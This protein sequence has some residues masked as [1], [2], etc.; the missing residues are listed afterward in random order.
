MGNDRPCPHQRIFSD[1]DA[2]QNSSIA[3]DSRTPP[4]SCHDDGPIGFVCNLPPGWWL[5]DKG[6]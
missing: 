5:A 1:R 3:A 6:R 4:N 2:P